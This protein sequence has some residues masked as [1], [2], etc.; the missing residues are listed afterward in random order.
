MVKVVILLTVSFND[1][2][3]P[4]YENAFPLKRVSKKRSRDKS[5]NGS[6]QR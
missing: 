3:Q 4:A 2:T 6:S 5:W 1:I